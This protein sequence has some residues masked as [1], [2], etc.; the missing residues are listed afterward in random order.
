M[1]PLVLYD[2]ALQVPQGMAFFPN[3]SVFHLLNVNNKPGTIT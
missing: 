3:F 1:S 2:N